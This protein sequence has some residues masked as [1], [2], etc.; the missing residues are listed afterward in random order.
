MAKEYP[1]CLADRGLS[2]TP[3]LPYRPHS[4]AGTFKSNPRQLT[5]YNTHRRSLLLAAAVPAQAHLL[6][7]DPEPSFKVE[8]SDR[9]G[10]SPFLCFPCMSPTVG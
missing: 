3:D 2:M 1:H 5:N 7:M 6:F 10:L 8:H 4:V 9:L